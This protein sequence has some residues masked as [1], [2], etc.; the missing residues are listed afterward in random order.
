MHSQQNYYVLQEGVA[1]S[2]YV[3]MGTYRYY[4]FTIPPPNPNDMRAPKAKNVSFQ[5]NSMHGDADIFVSRKHKYPNRMD[6]EKNSV[7][8]SDS[9]DM[10]FFDDLNGNTD[11]TGTYYVGVYSYQ[12]STYSLVATVKRVDSKGK[13]VSFLGINNEGKS[14]LSL[15]E[16]VSQRGSVQAKD[17]LLYRIDV[18]QLA[19]YEK[20]IKIQVSPLEGRFKIRAE[21]E[22]VPEKEDAS[23][24]I[25]GH[26]LSIS[27]KDKK[28][29]RE[30]TLYVLVV[31]KPNL[32]ELLDTKKN[33]QFLITYTTEDSY[34]YLKSQL[35]L[36]IKQ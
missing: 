20:P 30:G 31:P 1:V 21:Y 10:V 22:K 25:D 15:I 27:P 3:S 36:E 6:F 11:L 13:I 26:H 28:F 12:Y 33:Y 17:S 35:P 14:G 23:F 5:L 8:T 34:Y 18:K 16:G 19:G 7:K 24:S 32:V 29:K 2:D 4:S 9:F